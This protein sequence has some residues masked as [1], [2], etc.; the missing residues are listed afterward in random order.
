MD[1]T[2][3]PLTERLEDMVDALDSQRDDLSATLE[4]ARAYLTAGVSGWPCELAQAIQ[5]DIV[6]S[7]AAE[8]WTARGVHNG[9]MQL[10]SAEGVES[11]RVSADPLRVAWPKLR[12][13]GVLAGMGI[14]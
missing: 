14:A 8:L 13:A 1:D 9:V 6:L 11:Y 2:L 10:P 5:D 12:A 7:V 3:D 4:T